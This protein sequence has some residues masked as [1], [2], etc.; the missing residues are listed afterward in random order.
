VAEPED[1]IIEAAHVATATARSLW[2]KVSP[3]AA[4]P[5][6]NDFRRRL[7]LFLTT[8]FPDA[9]EIS[10]AESPAPR[11]LLARLASATPA[12]TLP[13]APFASTDGSR[14]RLPATLEDSPPEAALPTYRLLALEQAARAQRGTSAWLPAGDSLVRDLYLLAEAAAV[15]Q[16]LM[17]VAPGL[18]EELTEARRSARVS[19]PRARLT[20]LE[21]AVERLLRALLEAS[22]STPPRGIPAPGKPTESLAW[23]RAQARRMRGGTGRYRGVAPVFLWGLPTPPAEAAPRSVVESQSHPSA[24]SARAGRMRRRPRVRPSAPDEDDSRPGIWLPRADDPQESVEDPMGLQRPSD[25]EEQARAEDLGD[26]LSEL[27]E[28]RLVRTPEPAREVLVSEEPPPR[29]TGLPQAERSTAA[30]VYP[31]WDWRTER[32]RIKGAVVRERRLPPGDP[33]WVERAVRR[34]APLIR[35][36][37]RDFERLRPLRQTLRGQ[38]EGSDLDVDAYVVFAADRLAGGTPDGRLYL[39]ERRRRRDTAVLLLMDASASTD[40]WVAGS[41]RVVDVAKEGLIIV[42]E[43]LA[44]LGDRHAVFAF[45]GEGPERVDLLPIKRF[46]EAAGE[47]IRRRV[48]AVEPDGYTRLG[49]ALRHATALL[50]RE[51]RRHRLLLLLSDGRPNDVDVYEGRYGLE[52]TRQALAEA[53]VQGVRPFCLTIDREAPRYAA[54]V[55]GQRDYAVLRQ[56]ERMPEVLVTVLRRLLR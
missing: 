11:S 16:L 8:L 27:P 40:A 28:A 13:E 43:A 1:V 20:P 22:P 3:P 18:G 23:A 37:R 17:R 49:A 45:R 6:L 52:D 46:E 56:P 26:S 42:T 21:T 19:R 5:R 10:A 14:I 9:P 47:P 35:R 41:Q 2:L 34:H 33:A 53:R 50:A 7:G 30:L 12:H 54:R 4:P 32:Y 44:A 39:D 36:V 38:L 24:P 29:A 51:P 48:A 55:F 15:D 25:R 31:E